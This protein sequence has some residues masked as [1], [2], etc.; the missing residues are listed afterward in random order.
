MK[1]SVGQNGKGD[2][3]YHRPHINILVKLCLAIFRFDNIE[4]LIM[5][6]GG[7]K[8]QSL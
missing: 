2:Q 4:T 5:P 6:K 3:S 8:G 1:A 7:S